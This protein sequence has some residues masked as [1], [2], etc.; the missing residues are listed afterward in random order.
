MRHFNDWVKNRKEPLSLLFAIIFSIALMFSNGGDQL[1]TVKAWSLGGVG[2]ILEKLATLKTFSDLHDQNRWLRRQNAQL[3]IKNSRLQEAAIE[4]RRLRQLLEFKQEST[5]DLVPAKV[6][7]MQ[8]RG[9]VNSLLLDSGAADSLKKNM[10]VVTS[11]GLV[12]KIF[13]ISEHF[14]VV[15]LLFDRNFRASAMVQRS[16]IKGIVRWNQGEQLELGEVPARSDVVAGD[17]IVTSTVSSIFP[18]GIVIGE[19]EHVEREHRRDMFLEISVRP[20]V[21][22]NKLEEVFIVR[23]HQSYETSP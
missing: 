18:A 10:A 6:I 3:M 16:R 9:F 8:E 5:L 2:F 23:N 22:F 14:S 15:Q 12:G 17:V 1:H 7:G 19:V 11:Q 13:S 4:N 20:A 21:D